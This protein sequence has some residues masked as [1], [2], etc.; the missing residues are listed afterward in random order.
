MAAL[1]R[2]GAA[3]ALLVLLAGCE[4]EAAA[5]APRGLAL[6]P[7]ALANA[8]Y[9]VGVPG[10]LDTVTLTGGHHLDEATGLETTLLPLAAWGDLY[11]DD[12]R[13]VATVVVTRI[14][15]RGTLHEMVVLADGNGRAVQIAHEYLGD[16]VD[17]EGLAVADRSVAVQMQV[18][19]PNDPVCCPSQRVSRRFTI[20]G[21][22]PSP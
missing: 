3:A 22:T 19:G 21:R 15:G 7:A 18:H 13:E 12:R 16:R 1:A 9:I 10:G 11:G 14:P 20:Q 2:R 6:G 4:R 17:V 5:P 8:T